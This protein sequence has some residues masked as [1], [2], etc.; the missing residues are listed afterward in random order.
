MVN[1]YRL[2]NP[3]IKGEFKTSLKS[4]NSIEAGKKFYKNLSEHFNNN[5]PEFHFTIQKGSSGSGKY[6]HFKVQEKR[7]GEE[8]NFSIQPQEVKGEK[9][10]IKKFNKRLNV[11]ETKI[12][13]GKKKRK[14]RKKKKDDSDSD[15][16]L[17]DD[18]SSD[19]Y[20]RATTYI[21][22]VNYPIWYWWYDPYLYGL[23]SLYIPTF[24]AYATPYIEVQLTP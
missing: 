5:I 14:K 10:A 20:K 23:D 15:S 21:P 4:R 17:D 8:V 16:D 2:I 12:G 22:S 6:Y 24:Y 3:H 18:S 1:T 7:E 13:G 11:F 9:N 19:Y